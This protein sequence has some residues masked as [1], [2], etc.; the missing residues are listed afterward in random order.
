VGL[1]DDG[2]MDVVIL[3]EDVEEARGRGLLP[4]LSGVP[5]RE[6]A[7]VQRVPN[8][9]VM[10]GFIE[11]DAQRPVVVGHPLQH[12]GGQVGEELPGQEDDDPGPL[13]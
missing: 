8:A 9:L 3:D 11:G 2:P 13:G 4:Q 10:I 5:V 6:G 12:R 1:H 7:E